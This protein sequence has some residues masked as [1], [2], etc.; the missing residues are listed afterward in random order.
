MPPL[1][2]RS[3][4][5]AALLETATQAQFDGEFALGIATF[6]EA[7]LEQ[8]G[9]HHLK[10]MRAT[11][12]PNNSEGWSVGPYWLLRSPSPRVRSGGASSGSR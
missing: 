7:L 11:A 2:G 10:G 5:V 9:V 3:E 1:D 4:H 12:Y 6:A 8:G